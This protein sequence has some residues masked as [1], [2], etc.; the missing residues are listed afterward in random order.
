MKS[1]FTH[2]IKIFTILLLSLFA[3]VTNS[4]S[5][6]TF[7]GNYCPGPEAIGDEYAT[8]T[9]FSILLKTN[10]SST[11]D[12][13]TIRA[14]VDTQTQV[15]RLGMNIGNGGAALF[16]LYLD[17]DNN[18]ITGLTSDTFGGSLSVAGAEYIIEINTNASTFN[19]YSGSGTTL[20][21]LAINNGLAAMNGNATGCAVNGGNFL[22]FNIPFGSIGINICDPINPGVINITKLASVSGNSANSS[23]CVNT[24]LTFGIPLKG[25]VGPSSTVCYATNSTTLT[26]TGVPSTSITKWQSSISPFTSW[27]DIANTSTTYVAA[28]L[29][30]TTKYRAVFSSSGLCAGNN[31]STA[32]ATITVTPKPA[33]IV[34]TETICSGATFTWNG[35]DYTTNQSGTRFPGADGCTAD[36]VLNLTVTPKPTKVSTAVTICSDETY[37]WNA[38]NTDYTIGGTYLVTNDGCTANQELVLT[39]SAPVTINNSTCNTDDTITVDLTTLLPQGTPAGGTWTD[40]NNSGKLVGSV[41]SP[42]GLNQLNYVFE[43]EVSGSCP[44]IINMNTDDCPIVLG[45]GT[46][47]VNNAFSPNNDGINDEFFID[48]IDDTVCYPENTVEIYNR[49]GV[50]VFETKDYNNTSNKF[51]G[52]S[53][54]RTTISKSSGLPTGTYFYILNY[55]SVDGTGN[56]QANKKDG[57]LY[58]TR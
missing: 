34:T 16:R 44:L 17:T 27:T 6:D 53:G 13:G 57:Y 48:N 4:Y 49:W 22:E 37:T 15:L 33:D 54:G 7:D 42:Y 10:P 31:I 45:C 47:F 43:Y 3:S 29:I 28:S 23:R 38:N 30:Q 41:F 8:G 11:C 19:L 12:I 40:I 5:Q 9:F 32:E 52:F 36:Q 39:I 2:S 18:P 51:D 56:I 1:N 50:L 24:A 14:K 58:L 35:T 26:L 46:V 20:T 55:T 21:P 25:S